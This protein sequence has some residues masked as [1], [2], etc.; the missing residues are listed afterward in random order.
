MARQRKQIYAQGNALVRKF[1]MCTETVRISLFKSY[2]SSLYTSSLWCNY[3]SG[4]LRKLCVAYN[5]VFRKITFLPRDCSASLMFTTRDLPT[6][7]ILIRKHAY[8]FMKSAAE[9][10]NVILHSIVRSDSLFTSPLWQHWRNLLYA[11][12]LDNGFF[13]YLYGCNLSAI[14]WIDWLIDWFIDLLIYWFIDWLIHC[15][16]H[17]LMFCHAATS[18]QPPC[19]LPTTSARSR[20]LSQVQQNIDRCAES[21]EIYLRISGTQQSCQILA[22]TSFCR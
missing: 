19:R 10:R 14:K 2:C 17:S 22:W 18:C 15:P 4:S 7:K 11:P 9:S 21:R 5:N 1:Y 12:V 20:S 8:I 3:R 16:N 6:C 13:D